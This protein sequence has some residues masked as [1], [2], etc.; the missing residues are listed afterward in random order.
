MHGHVAVLNN[1]S[2]LIYIA[3]DK[4][5][6]R[7]VANLQ[8]IKIDYNPK[9]VIIGA[10]DE[11][12]NVDYHLNVLCDNEIQQMFANVLICQRLALEIAL[13]LGRNVDNP[14]GLHKVVVDKNI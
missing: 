14:K 4:I 6:K 13:K 8:K 3:V 10:K 1:K 7:S 9:L 2:T 12:L 11:E 5:S